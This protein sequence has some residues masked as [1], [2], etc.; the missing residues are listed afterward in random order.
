MKFSALSF[1]ALLGSAAAFA[2]SAQ[3]PAAATTRSMSTESTEES[4]FLEIKDD[5]GKVIA[6]Y[7]IPTGLP[8]S[9]TV[10]PP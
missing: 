7:A 1:L 10:A 2:P 3:R 4:E 9:N 8:N 5:K 6:T